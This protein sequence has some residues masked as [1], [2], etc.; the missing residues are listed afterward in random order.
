[1]EVPPKRTARGRVVKTKNYAI[2][3]NSDSESEDKYDS[4]DSFLVMTSESDYESPCRELKK[5]GEKTPC[6]GSKNKRNKLVYL[7]LTKQEVEEVSLE[8]CESPAANKSEQRQFLKTT[9]ILI[10]P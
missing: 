4:D 10:Y 1:M 5:N 9:S 2:T 3:K 6:K 7:D 8:S